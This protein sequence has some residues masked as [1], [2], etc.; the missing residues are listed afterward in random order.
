MPQ[1]L[2][3][4]TG[5]MEDMQAFITALRE[6]LGPSGVSSE[7]SPRS[8]ALYGN[9]PNPVIS[10]TRIVYSIG[11]PSQ[12]ELRIFDAQGRLLRTLV[13]A[14]RAAGFFDAPW[15]RLDERGRRVPAGCY[16]Y[17]LGAAEVTQTRRMILI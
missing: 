2:R 13:D 15:D 16:F 3:V 10:A 14:E 7:T 4:S 5:T 1:H 6:I 12:V 8:T 11:R 9:Y 17:R